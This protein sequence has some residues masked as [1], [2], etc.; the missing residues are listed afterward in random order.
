MTAPD[1]FSSLSSALTGFTLQELAGTGS[2]PEYRGWL[3][4]NFGAIFAE[5]L[6][7]WREIED[8]SVDP[9]GRE[10][11]LR[12]D[13]LTDPRLG[14]FA[15][16]L[17]LLW[18]TAVWSALPLE[19]SGIYGQRRIHERVFANAYPEALVWKAAGTHPIGANPPGFGSWALPPTQLANGRTA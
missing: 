1:P 9:G 11:A 17:A 19:W 16:N 14:P 12:R 18:Y 15:R 7:L 4:A 10:K 3:E 6:E 8:Q 5:L 13:V 2:A